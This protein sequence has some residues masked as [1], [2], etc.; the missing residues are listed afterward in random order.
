MS[1]ATATATAI[2]HSYNTR[3]AAKVVG[4]KY[5]NKKYKQGESSDDETDAS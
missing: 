2:S 4:P 5:Q 3:F 1:T